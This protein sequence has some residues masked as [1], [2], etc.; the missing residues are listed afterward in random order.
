MGDIRELEPNSNPFAGEL[1]GDALKAEIM[2]P[3][4]ARVQDALVGVQESPYGLFAERAT[5][6]PYSQEELY[7][8]EV[9]GLLSDPARILVVNCG[10]GENRR[11]NLEPTFEYVQQSTAHA[12]WI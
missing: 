6:G 5:V 4:R 2:E 7:S 3:D 12:G 10:R 11:G 8:P 1:T 9:T